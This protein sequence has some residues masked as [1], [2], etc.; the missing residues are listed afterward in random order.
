[1]TPLSYPILGRSDACT[2]QVQ[3][4][5]EHRCGPSVTHLREEFAVTPEQA[6]RVV[7]IYEQSGFKKTNMQSLPSLRRIVFFSLIFRRKQE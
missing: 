5:Q 1:M 6:L 4:L 2:K 7:T 3:A